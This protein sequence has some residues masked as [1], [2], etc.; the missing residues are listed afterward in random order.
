M[1]LLAIGA[2][3]T[4]AEEEDARAGQKTCVQMSPRGKN[5]SGMVARAG[6]PTMRAGVFDVVADGCGCGCFPTDRGWAAHQVHKI[7]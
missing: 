7:L 2:E 1:H 5:N 3:R 4:M 6:R